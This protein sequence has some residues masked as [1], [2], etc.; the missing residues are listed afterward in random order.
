MRGL[1]DD[2]TVESAQIKFQILIETGAG[3]VGRARDDPLRLTVG[4]IRWGEYVCL[5]VQE[6][7]FVTPH[8]HVSCSKCRDQGCQSPAVGPCEWEMIP[9]PFEAVRHAPQAGFDASPFESCPGFIQ[10]LS[11]DLCSRRQIRSQ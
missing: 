1:F 3:E 10:P 8:F 4:A 11:I 2:G 5:R 9:F 6:R 7:L